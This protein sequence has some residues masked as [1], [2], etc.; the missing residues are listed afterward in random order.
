MVTKGDNRDCMSYTYVV[1]ILYCLYVGTR[2][3]FCRN[4]L[5]CTVHNYI[6]VAT[7]VLVVVCVLNR[8]CLLS[9]EMDRVDNTSMLSELS[10]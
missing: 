8:N 5:L 6:Y 10:N 7:Y 2:M 4:P 9:I 1:S 3:D